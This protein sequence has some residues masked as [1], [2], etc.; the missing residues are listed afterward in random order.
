MKPC[1]QGS[2]MWG[3]QNQFDIS[4]DF[5]YALLMVKSVSCIF[6]ENSVIIIIQTLANY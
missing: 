5:H 3:Q 1:E 6:V 4:T 2:A